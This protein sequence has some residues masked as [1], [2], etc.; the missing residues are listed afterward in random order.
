[1]KRE[2]SEVLT[3]KS[4][5]AEVQK[6]SA[7]IPYSHMPSPKVTKPAP[8]PTLTPIPSSEF[9]QAQHAL[10]KEVSTL[11]KEV[12]N[13]RDFELLQVYKHPWRLA[14]YSFWKGLMVGLGSVIGATVLV[15]ILVYIL[16]QF[17]TVPF[18][19]DYLNNFT[20]K[21]SNQST[22]K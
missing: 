3:T 4:R 6:R 8:K 7:H 17:S 19:G 2:R 15:A 20:D 1:M 13:L 16:S 9:I 21:I 5:S 22:T 10:I 18:L 12:Q 14:L 11:S